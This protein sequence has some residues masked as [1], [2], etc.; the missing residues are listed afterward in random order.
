[1]RLLLKIAVIFAWMIPTVAYAQSYYP[2]CTAQQICSCPPTTCSAH[3][4]GAQNQTLFSNVIEPCEGVCG[5]LNFAEFSKTADYCE[6]TSQVC[7]NAPPASCA[8]SQ[9]IGVITY[10][11]ISHT[12]G[13]LATCQPPPM[14]SG[15]VY[16][17]CGVSGGK[18]L[19]L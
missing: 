13:G 14:P 8:P 19:Y 9:S 11:L 3:I 5:P 18:I 12:C 7:Q 15:R 4:T 6:V 2:A 16:F 17:T 10:T 1:M